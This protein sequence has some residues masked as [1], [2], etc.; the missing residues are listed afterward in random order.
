MSNVKIKANASGTADFTI[1]APATDSALTLT[2]PAETGSLLTN[3]SDLPAANLTGTLPAI[4]GSALTGVGGGIGYASTW[5]ITS[6]TG[7]ITSDT[8]LTSS[9]TEFSSAPFGKIGTS[10]TESVGIFTFPATGIWQVSFSF[11]TYQ[12]GTGGTSNE[13]AYGSIYA[14]TDGGSSWT[15]MVENSNSGLDGNDWAGAQITTIVNVSSTS[16][17]KVRFHGG[18]QDGVSFIGNTGSIFTGAVFIKLGDA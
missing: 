14:T 4:D 13:Y 7:T 6:S 12:T 15:K 1:E 9:W 10:L 11:R 2:L 18:S 5:G 17:V 3:A 16:N 8:V